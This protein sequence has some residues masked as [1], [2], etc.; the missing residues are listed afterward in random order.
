MKDK[1]GVEFIGF[2]FS[3]EFSHLSKCVNHHENLASPFM[4][5]ERN[6]YPACLRIS[7]IIVSFYVNAHF[8][9]LTYFTF[10]IHYKAYVPSYGWFLYPC[11]TALL[12]YSPGA[13]A[14]PYELKDIQSSVGPCLRVTG[15]PHRLSMS[16][17]CWVFSIIISLLDLS[18]KPIQIYVWLEGLEGVASVIGVSVDLK[19]LELH[20]R[21]IF[22]PYWYLHWLVQ[23][24]RG[25]VVS[26]QFQHGR[27]GIRW[28]DDLIGCIYGFW[29]RSVE[30]QDIV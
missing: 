17:I 7:L 19:K 6:H 29:R 26:A 21:H 12:D 22:Y 2:I 16:M 11:K 1:R 10:F 9:T 23:L 24:K 28:W 30:G 8:F 27:V 18:D 15:K 4:S 14:V 13:D 5:T 20:L 3:G 25:L